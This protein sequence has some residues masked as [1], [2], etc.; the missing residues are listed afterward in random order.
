MEPC[1]HQ[2]LMLC[3]FP[4]EVCSFLLPQRAGQEG[5]HAL[6]SRFK[7]FVRKKLGKTQRQGFALEYNISFIIFP[8][9]ACVLGPPHTA[10]PNCSV[11][12]C[13]L[14]PHLDPSHSQG[15]VWELWGRET[16]FSYLSLFGSLYYIL[17]PFSG[18]AQISGHTYPMVWYMNELALFS[19]C[20]NLKHFLL[21]K[22]ANIHKNR[23][24]S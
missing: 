19:S 16:T 23:E 21:W 22:F 12:S 11:F 13:L 15:W 5:R 18:L 20:G 4:T 1:T 2:P 7:Q 17:A 10:W 24:N 8:M 14:P 6:V 9:I 3:S